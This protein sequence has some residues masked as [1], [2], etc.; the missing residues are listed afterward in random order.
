MSDHS[1]DA[2]FSQLGGGQGAVSPAALSGGGNPRISAPLQNTSLG[3]GKICSAI[4]S[5]DL[6]SNLFY[7]NSYLLLYIIK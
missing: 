2:S 1:V 5:I 6:E 4:S 7:N 3:S